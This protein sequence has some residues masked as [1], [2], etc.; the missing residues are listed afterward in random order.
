MTGYQRLRAIVSQPIMAGQLCRVDDCC[1][2]PSNLNQLPQFQPDIAT[3]QTCLVVLALEFVPDSLTWIIE[4]NEILSHVVGAAAS[5]S[6]RVL[7]P[8]KI[9]RTD[10]LSQCDR[11]RHFMACGSNRRLHRQARAFKI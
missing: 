5:L 4:R 2:S 7:I 3:G 9:G 11:Q 1:T 6:F 8:L 10:W